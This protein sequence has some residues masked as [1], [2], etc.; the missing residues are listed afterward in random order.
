MLK[1]SKKIL[2]VLLVV[3]MLTSA[4]P[5][6]S[7]AVKA[8]S[9]SDD[10]DYQ[11]VDSLAADCDND[12]YIIYECADADC[13]AGYKEVIVALGHEYG[14]WI[15]IKEAS[16]KEKGMMIL[17][18]IRC[19]IARVKY[20]DKA[21]HTIAYYKA[22]APTCENTGLTEGSYCTVC[23]EVLVEQIEIP[24]TGHSTEVVP[25]TPADCVNS[26]L[27]DGEKCIY[28]G[29]VIVESQPI[30]A[31]G[32]ELIIDAVKSYDSTCTESGVK[33]LACSRCSYFEDS[34]IP[35]KGHTF[36]DWAIVNKFETRECKTCGIV[37]TRVIENCNH[38]A[39]VIKG[40]PAT[41]TSKGISD[42]LICSICGVMI[43]TQQQIAA[44]GHDDEDADGICDRAECGYDLTADCNCRCH[45]SGL[46]K[47]IFN[48]M[49]FFQKLLRLNKTCKCGIAHY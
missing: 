45:K 14:E 39:E 4:V 43:E 17:A 34:T 2:S 33:H 9:D 19:D 35:A 15:V 6:S 21:E 18:C 31:L 20:I 49:L 5:F 16:C 12:G 42:G 37:E 29:E 13:D 26:G 7:F 48:F 24:V 3:I 1:V 25:G 44:L 40:I 36:T 30:P 46:G 27:T 23:G 11:I 32:H 41:C 10:H 22:V 8:Q 38:K 47:M 28:C